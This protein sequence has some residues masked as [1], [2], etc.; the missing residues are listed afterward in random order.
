VDALERRYRRLLLAYPAEYRRERG[1]EIVG[2]LLDDAPPGRTRPDWRE[3]VDLVLGG[4]RRRAGLDVVPGLAAGARTAAPYALALAAGLS[5]FLLLSFEGVPRLPVFEVILRPLRPANSWPTVGIVSYL[6]WLYALGAYSFGRP[7]AARTALGLATVASAT[8]PLL[9]AA[10]GLDRPPLWTVGTLT[11]FGLI[12]LVGYRPP[13]PRE[14][15]ATAACAAAAAVGATALLAARMPSRQPGWHGYYQPAITISGLLVAA[16][17][18]VVLL[19]AVR[20]RPATPWLWAA[21]LI[22]LPGAWLGPWRLEPQTAEAARAANAAGD[23]DW[24]GFGAPHF[25]RLAQTLLGACV[26]VV[27]MGWLRERLALNATAEP[28]LRRLGRAA[29]AATGWAAGLSAFLWYVDAGP[30]APPVFAAWLLAALAAPSPLRARRL[31]VVL[32]LG[33]TALAPLCSALT[34]P[35]GPRPAVTGALLALGVVGLAGTFLPPA[36]PDHAAARLARQAGAAAWAGAAAVAVGVYDN[37]W[38]WRDWS[39]PGRTA[40][41]AT[42]LALVPLA[43]AAAAAVRALPSRNRPLWTILAAALA[44]TAALAV[45]HLSSWGPVLLLAMAAAIAAGPLA[46]LRR[47]AG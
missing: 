4:L 14:R 9:A 20:A 10:I 30:L 28:R 11:A 46:L 5:G 35:A 24:F 44:W 13:P 33:V 37:A 16:A 15:A 21:L 29:T 18:A 36:E 31:A 23:A 3:A 17:L 43:L 26:V 1:D 7:T 22:G 32:A 8:V 40:I 41:L 38:S 34:G 19:R 45:P 12:A 47:T 25:G 27:A 39:D 6:C 2:I 42:T